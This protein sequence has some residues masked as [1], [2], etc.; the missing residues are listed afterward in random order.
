MQLRKEM[1]DGCADAVQQA[2]HIAAAMQS[3][4][5]TRLQ[6]QDNSSQQALSKQQ[7]AQDA[8]KQQLQDQAAT[9]SKQQAAQHEALT[10]QE[11]QQRAALAQTTVQ[12]QKE[13][14][15]ATVGVDDAW[16]RGILPACAE[17]GLHAS[18]VQ[19]HKVMLMQ[20]QSEN[21]VPFRDTTGAAGEGTQG[22]GG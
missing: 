7:A 9:L 4:L 20:G 18:G 6:Q 16:L 10:K 17:H 22:M 3:D 2:Q 15:G 19:M 21:T 1:S 5:V 8:L 14:R 13:V 11:Q 12:L